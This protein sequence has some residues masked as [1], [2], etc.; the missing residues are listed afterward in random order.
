MDAGLGRFCRLKN[1]LIWL[2]VSN[3]ICSPRKKNEFGNFIMME[4]GILVQSFLL[5]IANDQERL[6]TR[7]TWCTRLRANEFCA[8]IA[9]FVHHRRLKFSVETT[10]MQE[11]TRVSFSFNRPNDFDQTLDRNPPP[12]SRKHLCRPQERRI[13]KE[14]YPL[15][16]TH[17]NKKLKH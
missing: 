17:K 3:R 2:C 16:Q 11:S 4:C 14:H 10:T 5:R 1:D 7:S 15:L 13:I 12:L 9:R 8:S 6:E